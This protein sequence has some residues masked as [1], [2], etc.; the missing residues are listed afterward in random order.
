MSLT[1]TFSGLVYDMTLD[2]SSSSLL[3]S[4]F[5]G[6]AVLRGMVGAEEGGVAWSKLKEFEDENPRGIAFDGTSG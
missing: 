1:S 3:V 4:D 5:K 6:R 2:S